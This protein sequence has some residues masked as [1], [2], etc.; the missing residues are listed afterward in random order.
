ME[1]RGTPSPNSGIK[2]FGEIL[3]MR[4]F[5]IQNGINIGFDITRAR[6]RLY[7]LD[8]GTFLYDP[9]SDISLINECANSKKDSVEGYSG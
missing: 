5:Y 7:K 8:L 6:V 3:F 4:I 1:V 9:L 2:P